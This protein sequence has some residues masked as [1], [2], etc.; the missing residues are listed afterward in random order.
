M[1]S[2]KSINAFLFLPIRSIASRHRQDDNCVIM[3][4]FRRPCPLVLARF[5]RLGS[6][7]VTGPPR[8]WSIIGLGWR[9][10]LRGHHLPSSR[11]PPNVY[12]PLV[13][14]CLRDSTGE[15]YSAFKSYISLRTDLQSKN[16]S[17]SIL[18]LWCNNLKRHDETPGLWRCPDSLSG[19]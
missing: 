14:L 1:H 10:H 4:S 15:D 3:K 9:H 19:R 5:C 16:S 8:F 6:L 2:E 18:A 11:H 7:A 17:T 12:I 13:G